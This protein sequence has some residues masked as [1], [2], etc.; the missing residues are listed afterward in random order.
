MESLDWKHN[1]RTVVI[2]RA[3]GIRMRRH[4]SWTLKHAHVLGRGAEIPGE[5]GAGTCLHMDVEQHGK[6]RAGTAPD[7]IYYDSESDARVSRFGEE[8]LAKLY[9]NGGHQPSLEHKYRLDSPRW[10]PL[11]S[12]PSSAPPLCSSSWTMSAQP[13]KLRQISLIFA[14]VRRLVRC[15][16]SVLIPLPVVEQ[17]CSPMV[18]H[19]TCKRFCSDINAVC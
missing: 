17:H 12:E 5:A 6:A 9:P 18:C 4:C 19:T 3:F 14:Y 1:K 13:S 16:H 8:R 11:S 10:R 7:W 15:F 2:S